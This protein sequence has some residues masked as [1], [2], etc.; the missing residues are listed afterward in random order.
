MV[1]I[2]VLIRLHWTDIWG[3]CVI[4]PVHTVIHP[5]VATF[6]GGPHP[7]FTPWY[8]LQMCKCIVLYYCEV[9]YPSLW[10][11]LQNS[12]I[13]FIYLCTHAVSY[14]L[15]HTCPVRHANIPTPPWDLLLSPTIHLSQPLISVLQ[16][17][18]YVC[19]QAFFGYKICHSRSSL[20]CLRR[21]FLQ[22]SKQVTPMENRIQIT[23]VF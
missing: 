23:E 15:I 18:A 12:D 19:G 16:T 2:V 3:Q 1:Y 7:R 14:N 13:Y 22:M 21:L 4:S 20:R 8:F 17:L 6:L 5:D 10:L 11:S 9:R